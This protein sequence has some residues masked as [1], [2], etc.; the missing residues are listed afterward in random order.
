MEFYLLCFSQPLCYVI[1]PYRL[2][3][4][5]DREVRIFV[6]YFFVMA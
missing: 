4:N 1:M 2:E 3:L 6:L 5:E